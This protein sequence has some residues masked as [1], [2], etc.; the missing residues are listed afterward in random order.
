M[1]VLPPATKT[2][3]SFSRS[4]LLMRGLDQ[5]LEGLYALIRANSLQVGVVFLPVYKN[6]LTA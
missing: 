4:S 5:L 3:E 1:S 2:L 6:D